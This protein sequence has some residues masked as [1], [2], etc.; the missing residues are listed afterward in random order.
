M[1]AARALALDSLEGLSVGDAFGER[2]FGHPELVEGL[3]ASRSLPPVPWKFTDDTEMALGIIEVLSRHGRVDQDDLAQVF[4]RRYRANPHRGYGGTA[5]DILTKLNL[6]VPWREASAEPFDGQ[7]SMGNGSAMRAAPLGAWFN[8][9]LARVVEE[10]RRAA[11]VTHWHPDGQAGGI[12]IAV[13]AAV[14]ARSRGSVLGRELVFD[15][16]LA[17]TPS[18]ET[19]L[20]IERARSLP[21]SLEVREAVRQ[22]GSGSRVLCFDTVPFCLW[23]ATRHT[24]DYAEAMWTTVAG[25]GDRDTTCAIVGGLVAARVGSTGIPADW[26]K[27]REPL[28]V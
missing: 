5:H 8:E 13:A 16:V 28:T 14:F 1:I 15:E 4:G 24:D 7:G 26:R 6:G 23:A 19:R 3:I 9:D 10:A 11:E 18:G 12:A 20:G 21:A 25:L 2:F 27:A 17:R 22:L